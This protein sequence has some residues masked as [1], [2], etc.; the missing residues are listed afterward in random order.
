MKALL[1]LFYSITSQS[2]AQSINCDLKKQ[3]GGINVYTCKA[4]HEKFKTLKAEFILKHTSLD[5]LENFLMRVDN[6]TTWQYN[7]VEAGVIQRISDHEITYRT[8]IEAPWP[9]ES[10]E[11]LMNFKVN[12]EESD[13]RMRIETYNFESTHTLKKGV[14]R[15]PFM[16]GLWTVIKNENDLHVEFVLRINPGGS[17]PAWLVNMAMAEGPYISFRN[18]KRQLE[19]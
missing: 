7:V 9:I 15:I 19:K 16:R 4:E 14:I 3:T 11:A 6:Y 10:R 12:R 13:Q 8:E 18:L 17:I 5:D 1:I 2:L